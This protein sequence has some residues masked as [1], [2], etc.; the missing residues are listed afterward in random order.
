M[1]TLKEAVA[2]ALDALTKIHPANM[3]WETETPHGWIGA[4]DRKA[5]EYVINEIRREE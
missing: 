3:S 5:L 2:Q 1:T 4:W